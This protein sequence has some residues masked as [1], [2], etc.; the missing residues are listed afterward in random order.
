MSTLRIKV[1]WLVA[2]A[3]VVSPVSAQ[4]EPLYRAH[5]VRVEHGPH[6]P[7]FA[8]TLTLPARPGPHPAVILVSPAGEHPRDELRRG[9]KHLAD[10]AARLAKYGIASL[11]V[12]NR[13]V[14][15]SKNDTWPT[16]S[17]SVS[18]EDLTKDLAGHFAWLRERPEIDRHRVGLL[19]HGDG[20]VPTARFAAGLVRGARR[21]AF[22]ILLSPSGARGFED[23]ARRQVARLPKDTPDSQR[24]KLR[25]QLQSA[26]EK[27][28][29]EG[30]S[31]DATTAIG[32]CFVAMGLPKLQASDQAAAFAKNFGQRWYRDF[33]GYRPRG[34]FRSIEVPVLVY[35]AKDDDRVDAVASAKTIESEFLSALA[36]NAKVSRIA[37]GGHFLEP[38]DGRKVL[39]E[40][41]VRAVRHFVSD[42]TG[43]LLANDLPAGVAAPPALVISDVTIVDVTAGK[44]QPG[45]TVIVRGGSIAEIAAM[46]PRVLPDGAKEIDG[47]G[48]Y[49]I[50]GLWDCHVHISM[51]GPD[52]YARLVAHGVTTVRDM[53]GDLRELLAAKKRIATGEILGPRMLL[54]GPFLDGE[55][56]NDIYRRFVLKPE[57]VEATVN[58]LSAA[59]VDFFKVHSR[60]PIDVM[61]EL[62]RVAGKRKIWFGGHTPAGITPLEASD[63]GMRSIEHADSFFLAMARAKNTPAPGWPQARAWWRGKDGVAAM[64]RIAENGTVVVPTLNIV[65]QIA[66]GMGGMFK[67]VAPWTRDITRA[68]HGAGVPLA[69]GTDFARRVIGIEPGISLHNEL[70]QLVSAGLS[71]SEALR[72]ATQTPSRR[73]GGNEKGGV[74]AVGQA[75][76]MVLLHRDPLADVRN[77]RAIAGVVMRGAWL[78]RDRLDALLAW[79]KSARIR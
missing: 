20:T 31:K 27:I 79:A 62:A 29:N 46:R 64:R 30:A 4:V 22:V 54:A 69:T 35:L 25:G 60:L 34:V 14:G 55:K 45:K 6:S 66:D 11:R 67:T 1:C 59:G 15:G 49:L 21:P 68:L 48:R 40:E 18:I 23:L 33:L 10:L 41:V 52:A 43:F 63:L 12:D 51:W 13:G 36:I 7:A 56:P 42:A 50:P 61:R 73:F 71:T 28:V 70:E 47:K 57:N 37:G 58:E 5:E 38:G 44:L 53:G 76:D 24:E 9:G 78:P 17:W 39:R 32:E 3:V 16:W 75:A 77:V 26:L 19:A 72:A 74:V 8:G 65:A 2:A